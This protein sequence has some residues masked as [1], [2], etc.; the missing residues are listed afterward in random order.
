M[1]V[2]TCI[3]TVVQHLITSS[4]RVQLSTPFC[5]SFSPSLPFFPVSFWLS[6][7]KSLFSSSLPLFLL[8]QLYLS[9]HPCLSLTLQMQLSCFLYDFL[10]WLPSSYWAKI[11]CHFFSSKIIQYNAKSHT[12]YNR[13]ESKNKATWCFSLQFTSQDVWFLQWRTIIDIMNHNILL[14]CSQTDTL[15]VCSLNIF[16]DGFSTVSN[17]T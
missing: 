10:Y 1:W 8:F 13:M 11:G 5:T 14:W 12:V 15:S 16:I 3:D 6:K 7:S 2:D 9:L 17:L 4:P